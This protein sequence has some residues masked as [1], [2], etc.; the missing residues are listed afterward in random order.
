MFKYLIPV[1][2]E[3]TTLQLPVGA[4]IV[5]AGV[6]RPGFGQVAHEISLWAEVP[7]RDER[8]T[9][10]TFTVIGTGH[11]IPHRGAHVGTVLDGAFVWHVY[12]V[13]L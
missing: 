3:P 2:D 12:E 5:E 4:T 7:T 13:P 8:T 10:R 9:R 11:E 1:Q 6:Q